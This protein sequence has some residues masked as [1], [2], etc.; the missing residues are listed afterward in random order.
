MNTLPKIKPTRNIASSRPRKASSITSEEI[1]YICAARH[2]G[3][4]WG[5]LAAEMGA[6]TDTLVKAVK[7][8]GRTDALAPPQRPP[9]DDGKWERPCTECGSEERRERHLFRCA[10]CRRRAERGEL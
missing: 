1:D 5:Q 8:A 9:E 2:E 6:D 10:K 4:T 7:L 3:R